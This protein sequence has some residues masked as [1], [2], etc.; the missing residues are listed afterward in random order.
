M[1]WKPISLSLLAL[2]LAMPAG[3]AAT[4]PVK[5]PRD[6]TESYIKVEVKGILKTGQMAIGA[7]TT[8]TSISAR[9]LSWEL[10]F[11][12]NPRLQKLAEKHN[13]QTVV[14]TGTLDVKQGV[15]V[16][17]REVVAVTGLKVD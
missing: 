3:Q 13:D 17:H 7:E 6:G 15:E 8:G 2:L 12:D 5:K 11:G 9:G 1:P 14:V 16:H 4:A 10:D